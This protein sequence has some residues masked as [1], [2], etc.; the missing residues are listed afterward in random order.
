MKILELTRLRNSSPRF[1]NF[2]FLNLFKITKEDVVNTA[3]YMD[4]V[5]ADILINDK[6]QVKNGLK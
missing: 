6:N 5:K 3:R 2:E 1:R 4:A